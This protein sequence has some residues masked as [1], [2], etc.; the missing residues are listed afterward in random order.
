MPD[1]RG[2]VGTRHAEWTMPKGKT[3]TLITHDKLLPNYDG[4]IGIKNGF[5]VA[6]QATY[7]GAATRGGHTIIATLMHSTVGKDVWHEDAAL[8]DW[9]FAALG[10]VT[11]VGQLV[12]PDQ[13]PL[14][15]ASVGASTSSAAAVVGSPTRSAATATVLKQAI[16]AGDTRKAGTSGASI[17]VPLAIAVLLVLGAAGAL[18]T[19][20]RRRRG[21]DGL[22][23]SLRF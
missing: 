21:R 16:D 4:A 20:R 5:T 18:A 12:E 22:E 17:A 2:Y 1:F 19:L 15:S 14:P 8:M 10:K 11:P 13:P 23:R 6:A 9:G 7:I 3:E